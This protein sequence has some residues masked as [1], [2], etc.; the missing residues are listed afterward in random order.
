MLSIMNVYSTS[1][2]DKVFQYL[3]IGFAFIFPLSVYAGN[4]LAL[5]I[6]ILWLLSGNYK[7]K[8][9][10]IFES[11]LAISSFL[12]FLVF[13]MSALWSEDKSEGMLLAKK[14]I[15]FGLL[16]PILITTMHRKNLSLYIN[17]FLASMILS[18][19]FSFLIY[20]GLIEHISTT[21]TT[22]QRNPTPF[23]SH[24]SYTPFLAITFY[25]IFN[26]FL[27]VPNKNRVTLAFYAVLLLLIIFNI[28][29]TGGRAG[30]IAFFAMFI[31]AVIQKN[32]FSI[33]SI[34]SS[35]IFLT[36]T[37]SL[38]YSFS[39]IFKSRVDESMSF[40]TN[41]EKRD[42]SSTGLRLTYWRNSLEMFSN[43][44]FF[45]VGVGDFNREYQKVNEVNSPNIHPTT[46]PHNMYLY[47]ASTAGLF[48]IISMMSIFYFLYI[49]SR[50]YDVFHKNK[51]LGLSFFFLL[52]SFFESYL[53][54]HYTSFLFIYLVSAICSRE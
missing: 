45:G 25:F 52:I 44:L 49:D 23:M 43:N 6:L 42:M 11:K 7:E 28:F 17:S 48:G 30:Q 14:M 20:F 54:G 10:K 40:F 35:F 9:Q 29:I 26:R 34:F 5:I 39:D 13:L 3:I 37:F 22:S 38:A 36:L 33:R 21:S 16:L 19:F 46:N 50:K 53:L 47:V 51:V 41:I 27:F 31:L 15:D 32:K 2:L 4:L 8:F 24:V 12:F 1:N 18:I